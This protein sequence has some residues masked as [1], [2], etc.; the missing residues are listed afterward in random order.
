MKPSH[1]C[2]II[3]R[4]LKTIGSGLR[5]DADGVIVGNNVI[6]DP[7]NFHDVMLWKEAWLAYNVARKRVVDN[8]SLREKAISRF[9]EVERKNA[10]LNRREGAFEPWVCVY[11]LKAAQICVDVIGET[12]KMKSVFSDA[13]FTG[14]ASTS[15]NRSM[16]H[17]ALKWWARPQL[18]VTPLAL[19]HLLA[20]KESSDLLTVAWDDPGILSCTSYD[21]QT[22][23]Y[24]I[25]P[26]SRFD[27]VQKDAGTDRT[28]LIEPD[29]NMLLQR[30]VG[31]TFRKCLKRVG[32]NL[33][34]QA[35]NQHLAYIGSYDNSVATID[36][37]DASNSLYRLLLCL[38]LPPAWYELLLD[39]RSPI[40][41]MPDG[42]WHVLEMISSMGNGYTFEL[43]S[44][45]FYCLTK[46]VVELAK[47]DGPVSVYGDDIILPT[48]CAADLYCLFSEL[49]LE[50]NPD[51]SYIDGPFRESCGS[52]F[53]QGIDVTPF[54]I[55]E[56]VV[57]GELIRV[58]NHFHRWSTGGDYMSW[59]SDTVHCAL[60]QQ[61]IEMLP[62]DLRNQVP[63][64][65]ANTCGLYSPL[66]A[67]PIR[68]R[69]NKKG[70][71]VAIFSYLHCRRLKGPRVE[72]E[73]RWLYAFAERRQPTCLMV[74][75]VNSSVYSLSINRQVPLSLGRDGEQALKTVSIPL[76]GSL[77]P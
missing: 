22:P 52:H 56:D 75:R 42:S 45:L 59:P 33:Q 57:D 68:F 20:L 24:R 43:E 48:S 60:L 35:H 47:V 53:F 69:R 12:P 51:K 3:R 5:T 27:T 61:L 8:P 6:P 74:E 36:L 2:N 21:S 15:R 77:I 50:V 71:T 28:I 65:Y 11:L 9:Y 63:L 34:S 30:G 44:L 4:V 29:G 38:V 14:G 49:G 62:K 25:V 26:G 46:A 55:K 32:I 41:K 10:A 70:Y 31:I 23:F 16:A 66:Y 13:V 67:K 64:E 73:L 1:S 19:R 39:L 76:T 37:R 40:C 17:P 7:R 72:D 58:I 18:E 54:Y